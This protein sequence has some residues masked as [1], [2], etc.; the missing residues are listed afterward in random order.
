MTQFFEQA[1]NISL[2][3]LAS[4]LGLR[5]SKDH[6]SAAPCPVC[7][8]SV[9]SRTKKDHRPP[10]GFRTD[11]RGWECQHCH[12]RGDGIDLTAYCIGGSRYRELSD[13]DK[14]EVR[15]W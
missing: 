7:G 6:R 4:R 2:P 13:R 3:V 12:V 1:R 15:D 11:G 14:A 8:H 9:R 10:L 5:L